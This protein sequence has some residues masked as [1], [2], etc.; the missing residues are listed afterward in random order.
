MKNVSTER[1]VAAVV[2]A[3]PHR[4]DDGEHLARGSTGE[5]MGATT[6]CRSEAAIASN[7]STWYGGEKGVGCAATSRWLLA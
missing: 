1:Q 6:G 7:A 4:K 3:G 2:E 5:L